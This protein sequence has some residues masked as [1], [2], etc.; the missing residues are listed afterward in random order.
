MPKVNPPKKSAAVAST[1]AVAPK[2]PRV[3]QSEAARTPKR[4]KILSYLLG[5]SATSEQKA[6]PRAEVYENAGGSA[7]CEAMVEAG[8]LGKTKHPEGVCLYVTQ[9]GKRLFDK[10]FGQDK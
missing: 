10:K 2:A 9:E 8:H 1:A 7:V 6:V 5:R 4:Q 3:K